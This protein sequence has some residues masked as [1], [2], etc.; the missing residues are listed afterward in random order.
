[1]MNII[2]YSDV[3]PHREF[4]ENKVEIC[5]TAGDRPQILSYDR[6]AICPC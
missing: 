6:I 4:N 1:M 2:T 5:V 3:I